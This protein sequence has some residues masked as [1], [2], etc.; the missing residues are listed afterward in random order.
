MALPYFGVKKERCIMIT[1]LLC[2]S[3]IQLAYVMHYTVDV[4]YLD[5]FDNIPLLEHFTLDAAMSQHNEHRLFFP[6]LIFFFMSRITRWSVRA[7]TFLNWFL[8]QC[9]ALFLFLIL[10]KNLREKQ[11][12]IAVM[13]TCFFLVPQ[14]WQN[15]VW[16]FQYCVQLSLCMVLAAACLLDTQKPSWVR[17]HAAALCCIIASFSFANGLISWVAFLPMITAGISPRRSAGGSLSREKGRIIYWVT[18]MMAV[19]AL[20]FCDFRP[21]RPHGSPVEY[22]GIA[23]F[24]RAGMYFS[25]F[26]SAGLLGAGRGFYAKFSLLHAAAGAALCAWCVAGCLLKKFSWQHEKTKI[27]LCGFVLATAA[28]AAL[29][30]VSYG[31]RASISSRYREF[32]LLLPLLLIAMCAAGGAHRTAK[33]KIFL[34]FLVIVIAAGGVAGWRYAIMEGIDW[35]RDQ[36]MYRQILRSFETTADEDLGQVY[37]FT[38][39]ARRRLDF[40]K[41]N[42]YSVFR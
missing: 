33:E 9:S 14:Y 13:L 21:Y 4:I 2:A 32:S 1:A 18:I 39:T 16:G 29:G 20:Y 26:L 5:Q 7:E 36:A 38:D 40:L 19:Y 11:G 37:P 10:G 42:G 34:R 17:V 15:L 6:R 35:R 31:M 28:A 25:S 3:L 27:C 23:Y 24:A 41:R 22:R 12:R 30:R 8:V